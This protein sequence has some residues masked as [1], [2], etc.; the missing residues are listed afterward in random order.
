MW[1]QFQIDNRAAAPLRDNWTDAAQDC[2]SAGFGSWRSNDELRLN[3]ALGA[4]I[5]RI[6]E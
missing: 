4:E 3:D 2:V 6:S 5:K 1:Y